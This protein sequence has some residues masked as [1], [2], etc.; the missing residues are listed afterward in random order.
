LHPAFNNRSLDLVEI[1]KR[2]L[3]A[4]AFVEHGVSSATPT[5]AD[6][7]QEVA[8]L[9]Q[10]TLAQGQD[11]RARFAIRSDVPLGESGWVVKCHLLSSLVVMLDR[12]A[13]SRR[14][15]WDAMT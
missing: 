10:E 13:P 12:H 14:S 11:I 9:V 8:L 1:G 2:H 6:E 4:A 15:R 5:Q 7:V 3:L